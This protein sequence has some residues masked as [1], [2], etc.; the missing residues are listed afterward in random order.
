[1]GEKRV[2]MRKKED[3]NEDGGCGDAGRGGAFPPDRWAC[4][5]R[6]LTWVREHRAPRTSLFH[7]SDAER[8][9][10]NVNGLWYIRKTEGTMA[11]GRKFMIIDAWNDEDD[12]TVNEFRQSWT[13]RTTFTMR[14]LA[15]KLKRLRTFEDYDCEYVSQ[16]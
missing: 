13:G 12:S 2:E 4:R 6:G 14:T 11:D 9:P 3:G 7:P 1:M 15:N 8:G 16:T 10:A 5:G